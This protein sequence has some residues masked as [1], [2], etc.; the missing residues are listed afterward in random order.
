MPSASPLPDSWPGSARCPRCCAS[1][2]PRWPDV[3]HRRPAAGGF[4]LVEHAWHLADL[5]REGYGARISRLLA[6]TAPALPDFDGDRIAREREYL[7]GDAGAR[8]G[9]LRAGARGGTSSG[10]R[11]WT[12]PPSR[13]AGLKKAWARSRW[14]RVPRMMAAHDAGHVAELAALVEELAPAA[15]VLSRLR[16]IAPIAGEPALA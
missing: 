6:E 1:A 7:A 11:R 4:A 10:W 12:R 2:R 9:G 16:S 3:T 8:A 5:E 14:A 15:P 13:G